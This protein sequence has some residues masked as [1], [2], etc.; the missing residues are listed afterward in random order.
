MPHRP[1]GAVAPAADSGFEVAFVDADG[2]ER[3]E[4]L[5]GCLRVESER[6]RPVRRFVSSPGQSHFPRLWWFSSAGVHAGPSRHL[7]RTVRQVQPPGRPMSGRMP[8]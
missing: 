5:S 2:A 4:P 7:M 6:V 3:H 1:A 8:D